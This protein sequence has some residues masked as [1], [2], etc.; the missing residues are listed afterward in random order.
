MPEVTVL[1]NSNRLVS[2]SLQRF[3]TKMPNHAHCCVP[4]CSNRK[5]S[6]KIGLFV[7]EEGR[8]TKQRLCGQT[9]DGGCKN[10]SDACKGLSFHRLPASE[11]L[12]KAWIVKI[13]RE[14]TPLTPNSYVCGVHFE[15]QRRSSTDDLPVI[16]V[17]SKPVR[18]RRTRTSAGACAEQPLPVPTNKAEGNEGDHGEESSSEGDSN[19]VMASDEPKPKS[20][21]DQL[22][23][24]IAFL[25]DKYLDLSKSLLEERANSA[26]LRAELELCKERCE[27][28][29]RQLSE[30][31]SFSFEK[32][33]NK[34][35]IIKFYTGLS[36]EGIEFILTLVGRSAREACRHT[37]RDTRNFTGLDP[38][39]R[40]RILAAEDELF[41]TLM[42]LRHDFPEEDLAMRFSI[43]QTTVSR[44]FSAWVETLDACFAEV[45]IWPSKQTIT[46]FMP[47]VFQEQYGDTRV[48]VDGA[49][50]EIQQP[51]NPDTQSETWSEYKSRNTLKF[52]LGVTPNG[53]PSFVSQ[54]FGGRISDKELMQRSGIFNDTLTGQPRF[55]PSDAVMA[56]R[57]FD[58][59]DL[60]HKRGI[61]LNHPPSLQ[62][63]DQLTEGEVVET[64]RIASLRIHVERAIERIKNFCILHKMPNNLCPQASRL[65]RVCT[66]LTTLMPPLVPPPDDAHIG[67]GDW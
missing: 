27:R 3:L 66:F 4:G 60:L 43:D 55:S 8:Y 38:R 15:G 40:K 58:I 23:D 59:K 18:Q 54:C 63:R 62:G 37:I 34:P 9:S 20:E 6:C 21:I 5:N 64:R 36:P 29:A 50:I 22:R 7:D 1:F 39:G 57:G 48:I 46:K 16:F 65:V 2:D 28:Q 10:R 42:K 11:K 33:K 56:D 61:K 30:N 49:E 13:R 12:R 14:N 51:Q 67:L 45:P 44:V 52:L 31:N 25:Q 47:L 53:V 26:S 35:T 24:Q 41:L 19:D 32:V 17:W